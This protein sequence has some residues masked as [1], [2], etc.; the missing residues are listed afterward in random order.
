MKKVFTF[1]LSA[2]L[3]AVTFSLRGDG[4][5]LPSEVLT[6]PGSPVAFP[7]SSG[8]LDST[9]GVDGR[10]VVSPGSGNN[11]AQGVA[12]Q[13]DGRIVTVGYGYDG[14]FNNFAVTR[15]NPNGS[16]DSTF[17]GTGISMTPVG[18]RDAESYGVAI[19]SDGKIIVVGAS[20]NGVNSDLAIVRFN[21]NG[22]LDG[23][24]GTN[25]QTII[26]VAGAN[27]LARSVAIQTDGKI[28]VAGNSFVGSNSDVV[29]IRLETNG[30][31]DTDFDGNSGIG[32]GI[33]TTQVG[34][35]NDFGYA[36]RIQPNGRILVSGYYSAPLSTD[37]F[38]LRYNVDGVLDTTFSEDGRGTYGF[39]PN[40]VDEALAM[41]L[42]PDGRIVIAGCIRGNGRLNDYLIA[43]LN[44][45]G[46]TDATFGAAGFTR[47]EFS[48]NPDIALGV[49]VQ[50]DGK[51]VAAGFASNGTNNDFGVARVNADGSSDATFNGTGQ[52]LTMFGS[53]VESANAAAIQADGKIVVVGRVVIGNARFGIARY[54]YGTNVEEN[55]GFIRLDPTTDIRFDN[56]F[57]TGLSNITILAP[58]VAP[59]LDSGWTYV[60]SA[61]E[62]RTTAMFSGTILVRL[63]L[64]SNIDAQTFSAVRVL[65]FED[66]YW[67]DKTAAAPIRDFSS[68]TIYASV[69]S[70]G[71]IAA[72]LPSVNALVSVSGRVTTPTGLGLRNAVVSIVDSQGTRR[73]A[74]TS[75]FG[76]YSFDNLSGGQVYTVAVSSKR[77]RFGPRIIEISNSLSN[78]DFVG[79]E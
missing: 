20:F 76:N 70:Q 73:T 79:L 24:F 15:V 9:F 30:L 8:K 52:Q 39:S 41:A 6:S 2:F 49:A 25:G 53:S 60:G 65:Q 13:A 11:V 54:G 27:D 64:P 37:S 4:I 69:T 72:A 31:L 74:T 48:P 46:S 18:P 59:P 16:L 77:Y 34:T 45:D 47:V 32:Q 21:T 35:G 58:S 28:V 22:T 29:V 10:V 26:D 38:V 66:G 36:V 51:I 62:L 56:A 78:L 57:Q 75:S 63:T 40:D 44:T 7:F 33:V 5:T 1:V 68:R 12:V 61:R 42:Q 23:T 55:D 71:L 19:Q 17:N 43:R 3:V 67:V 50:G 14:T